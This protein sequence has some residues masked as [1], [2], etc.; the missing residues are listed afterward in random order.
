MKTL[1][2]EW[3]GIWGVPPEALADLADRVTLAAEP[4]ATVMKSE[5]ESYVQSL[6]RLA[7]P[8]AGM[9]LWRNNCGALP[10]PDTDRPIRFGL[11]NDSKQLN[12]TIKSG[13][14]IGWQSE[15]ITPDMIGS[16]FARFVSIECKEVGWSGVSDDREKAQARWAAMVNAAGGRAGFSV[17]GIPF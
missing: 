15:L 3:A 8:A 2:E 17:G 1:I 14:L 10:N 5:S 7:A 13:D 9:V 6:V 11:A 12:E 16:V 4:D